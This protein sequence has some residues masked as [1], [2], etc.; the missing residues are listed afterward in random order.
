MPIVDIL[1]D[2]AICYRMEITDLLLAARTGFWS[3]VS[4]SLSEELLIMPNNIGATTIHV[5][6]W[7]GTLDGIPKSL[8]TERVLSAQGHHHIYADEMPVNQLHKS[9]ALHLAAGQGNLSQLPKQLLTEANFRW[10][11]KSGETVLHI[12]ALNHLDQVPVEVMTLE[13]MTIKNS[14]KNN[15]TPLGISCS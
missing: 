2:K 15:P 14:S 6:A 13:N 10:S 11:D 5:A 3:K 9:T 12:A 1:G 8:L 7:H 4:D